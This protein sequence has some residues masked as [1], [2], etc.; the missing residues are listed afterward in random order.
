MRKDRDESSADRSPRLSRRQLLRIGSLGAF[1]L[2]LARLFQAEAAA[3]RGSSPPSSA[4]RLRDVPSHIALP[5]VMYNVVKLPGQSAGYLG[6]AFDPLQ[7]S[8]DPNDPRFR[9]D[10]LNLPADLPLARLESRQSLLAMIDR[11]MA[12]AEG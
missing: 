2:N 8:R 4:P 12:R 9:V 7:I 3:A 5:H 1:G 11:Q 10:E 6:S